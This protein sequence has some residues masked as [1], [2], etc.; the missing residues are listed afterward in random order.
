MPNA[1]YMKSKSVSKG[2]G[3]GMLI[4]EP[5]PGIGGRHREIHKELQSIDPE[6]PFEYALAR[7]VLRAKKFMKKMVLIPKKL[8]MAFKKLLNKTKRSFLIYLKRNRMNKNSIMMKGNRIL[9]NK[10]LRKYFKELEKYK[11]LSNLENEM[12]FVDIVDKISF[13]ED[14]EAIL[15][16]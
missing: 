6:T 9:M 2:D 10:T 11:D 7:S 13:T 5:R 15:F 1:K 3:I 12:P 14:L 4:E 8:G 16:F